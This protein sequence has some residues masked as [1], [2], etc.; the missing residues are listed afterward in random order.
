MYAFLGLEICVLS[1]ELCHINQFWCLS[2]HK[3]FENQINPNQSLYVVRSLFT[4]GAG[5]VQSKITDFTIQW[6]WLIWFSKFLCYDKHRNRFIRQGSCEST[7]IFGPKNVYL[8]N[9][10]KIC[11][12]YAFWTMCF[13]LMT[14]ERDINP[15]IFSFVP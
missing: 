8:S 9:T 3:I 11:L 5:H 6:F 13:T 7:H 15:S 12:N 2:Y 14:L 10:R 1:L 4:L